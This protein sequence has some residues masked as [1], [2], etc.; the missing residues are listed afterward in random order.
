LDRGTKYELAG[1]AYFG[2]QI[3]PNNT[4][5]IPILFGIFG[6]DCGLIRFRGRLDLAGKLQFS[7]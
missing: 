3:T 7:G 4:I 6:D 1:P 2:H 5:I